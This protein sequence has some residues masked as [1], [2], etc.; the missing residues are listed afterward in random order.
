DKT[1]QQ[2]GHI[3]TVRNLPSTGDLEAL[4]T[5]YG[6]ADRIELFRSIARQARKGKDWWIG[7]EDAMPRDFDLYLG[8]EASAMQIHSYAA[9]VVPGLLQTT[10]YA[11]AVIRGGDPT[12]TDEEVARRVELRMARQHVLDRKDPPHVWAVLDEAVLRRQ[13]GGPDVSRQ[14]LEHL[15]TLAQ[16]PHIDL[17][18]LP[19]AAG[20]HAGA[21]GTFTWL[22]FPPELAGGGVVYLDTRVRCVYYEDPADILV[23]RNG[24]TRLQIQATTP[25]NTPSIL[26]HAAKELT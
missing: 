5:S 23:Y 12:L 22:A 19:A 21:E 7:F 13:I 4:L 16:R 9:V 20:A 10:A 15:V 18:V 26:D 6:A 14:Q 25:A 24:M 1:L 3:E 2:I 8:L 17:Q 11:E